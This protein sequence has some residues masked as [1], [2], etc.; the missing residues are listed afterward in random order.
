M[1]FKKIMLVTFVLLAVLTIG[2]VSAAE[3]V[4]SDDALTV[5]DDGDSLESPVNDGD[6]LSDG[7]GSDDDS[8]DDDDEYEIKF[9]YEFDI[10]DE[11]ATV[12]SM[13]C[14]EDEEGYF[15]Y[16]V[17]DDD[18][19][20]VYTYYRPIVE[21]DWD[22][23]FN[24][25]ASDL[26]IVKTGIYNINIYLVDDLDEE[27]DEYSLIGNSGFGVEA[28]DY[29]QFRF[30]SLDTNN[31]HSLLIDPIF[32]VYC[33][34]DDGMIT[35]TVRKGDDSEPFHTSQKQIS[36][37]DGEN[38]LY[39]NL[40]ELKM[41]K[42]GEYFI[43]VFNGDD[44][45]E[46]GVRVNVVSPIA[47]EEVSYI[48]S[49]LYGGLVRVTVPSN[50]ADGK[51]SL[52]IDENDTLALYLY[53]FKSIEDGTDSPYWEYTSGSG[54]TDE[55]YKE[56]IIDNSHLAGIE[57]GTYEIAVSLEID[58]M[59]MM[60]N[61]A[62]VTFVERNAHTWNN[63]TIEL[64]GAFEYSLD[65]DEAVVGEITVPEDFD[66]TVKLWIADSDDNWSRNVSLSDLD[67]QDGVY[68]V[69]PNDFEGLE[70]GTYEVVI[71]YYAENGERLNDNSDLITFRDDDDDDDDDDDEA[72]GVVII[73]VE[74]EEHEFDL[75]NEDDLNAEF[76]FVSVRD[77]LTGN[78]TISAFDEQGNEICFFNVAL[79]DICNHEPDEELEGF[80]CYMI[81]LNNLTDY[82]QFV[83]YGR[84]KVAF[85]NDDN[86]EID[87][88][89]YDIELNEGVVKFWEAE[90]DT[91]DGVV[92]W[93]DCETEINLNLPGATQGTFATV[94]VR[95]DLTGNVTILAYSDDD[96]I[97][98]FN[99]ALKDIRFSDPDE[100]LEGFTCYSITLFDLT[101]LTAFL[102]SGRFEVAFGNDDEPEIDSSEY[103]VESEDGIVRF[104]EADDDEDNGEFLDNVTFNDGNAVTNDVIILIPL[105]I[106]D[107]IDDEFEVIVGEDD[108]YEFKLSECEKNENGYVIRV[109]DLFDIDDLGE[110]NNF[111]I[112]IQFYVNDEPAY[113]AETED[114][115]FGIA[116]FV[117]PYIFDEAYL[118]TDDRVI[119]FVKSDDFDDE[120]NVTISQEGAEDI[121][122]TFKISEFGPEDLCE[123]Y[124]S[125]LNITEKGNYTIDVLFTKDGEP[126]ANSGNVSVGNVKISSYEEDDEGNLITYNS[127]DQPV[128][129]I[130]VPEDA[131]GFVEI[132]VDDAQVGADYISFSNFRYSTHVPDDGRV[133][134]LN[135][136]NITEGGY[137]DVMVSVFD[138]NRTLLDSD[139]IVIYFNSSSDNVT[140]YDGAYGCEPG[141]VIEFAIGTHLSEGQ[142]YNIYFN[143]DLAGNFT[144]K[145]GLVISDE[146]LDEV[147]DVKLL[148]YGYYHV[149]VK[150]FNGENETDFDEGEFS[151]YL[152]KLYR[153][154]DFYLYGID[155]ALI[156]F[157]LI[158]NID[159]S[160][161]LDAYFVHN[162]G[163]QG[164]DD[165]M[166]FNPYMGDQLYELYD[167]DNDQII[168]DVAHFIAEMD[169][170]SYRLD[171]GTNFIYVSYSYMDD[172]GDIVTMGGLI[173]LEVIDP[174]DPQLSISVSDIAE[175]ESATVTVKANETFSGVVY[176]L[177]GTVTH[178]VT[179]VNGTGTISVADL[180][181]GDYIAYAISDP[182]GVFGPGEANDTFVVK[183]KTVIK[184]T[185]V[186]T[187]YG[188]SKDIVITLTDAAGKALSGK[189]VVVVL[190]GVSKT[191]TTDANGQAVFA[192]GT[193]LVPK[194]YTATITFNGDATFA[195][196]AVSAKVVV[197]KAKA[198]LTAKKKTFKKAKK[199]K[200][201]TITLK[202]GK[203]AISKVKVTIIVK[204][205]GKKIKITKKTNAKGKATFNLKKLTKK[206]KYTATVKFAGNKY[207]KA[208]TKKAKITVK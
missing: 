91:E 184:A 87:S 23:Y 27:L 180:P 128:F 74:G 140:F 32:A 9:S 129:V 154:K 68:Q 132:L 199:S 130:K 53:E 156:S 26:R 112:F 15:V 59:D 114:D 182:S 110:S 65:D 175:G 190:N 189:S 188:T 123:L 137:Y 169:N 90:D 116:I 172:D 103:Y 106:P 5:V 76:V 197:N 77:D 46:R 167:A 206:G 16:N 149:D 88:R 78:I 107:E 143:D 29:T 109:L 205:K 73:A 54:W 173:A 126:S 35:V 75:D 113:Y 144:A 12:V 20:E 66:G 115:E 92:I 177:I 201:Y 203:K 160:C 187:T 62:N 51:I 147:F 43:S 153:D 196:S 178:N 207:Y 202:A 168:F 152:L 98:F 198:T 145:Y 40:V 25:T 94:S 79:E 193:K 36:E 120:F 81:S 105:D 139:A 164:R 82:N 64:F 34:A 17:S 134:V 170:D 181:A 166:V 118:L 194:T 157:D 101:N 185:A 159:E 125:D 39:W 33:P 41:N 179:V 58:G 48:N 158:K 49:T 138:E 111:P 97:Y 67:D 171:L 3:D 96:V 141:D 1:R 85:G 56:Y 161:R 18:F 192:V 63:V 31:P 13:Y 142:Y 183:A 204:A 151:I 104:I 57:R 89:E 155:P 28:V 11:N 83:S 165:S 176:V 84:F 55:N 60:T 24:V 131:V 122:K 45:I 127:I 148:K 21:N 69:H 72:D 30:V 86:P 163:P 50:I 70:P 6:L 93:V 133:I 174:A 99:K 100:Q 37:K 4:T 136:L 124:L 14:P 191:L 95:D 195:K 117:S 22:T 146:Y 10:T 19:K 42:E 121:V 8:N 2:A 108:S 186:T 7:N 61:A 162:W 52:S 38:K 71:S 47:I 150:F 80:T 200:K 119:S 102:E 44:E 135:D 208:A